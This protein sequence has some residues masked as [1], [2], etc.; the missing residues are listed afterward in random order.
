MKYKDLEKKSKEDLQKMLKDLKVSLG[1]L[2]FEL[3]HQALKN[4][5]QIA[6]T[7]RDIAR[8]LTA[9]RVVHNIK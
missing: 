5:N 2:Q 1:R 6:Q 9:L 4:V 3:K 7:K 8:V